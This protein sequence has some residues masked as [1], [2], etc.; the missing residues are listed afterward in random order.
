M[1]NIKLTIYGLLALGGL[2]LCTGCGLFRNTAKFRE[3]AYTE[4]E[5]YSRSVTDSAKTYTDHRADFAGSET[6]VVSE[7]A[8]SARWPVY[9]FAESVTDRL[10]CF[11]S[12]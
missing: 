7:T 5:R 6:Q 3:T 1:K 12:A 11:F 9:V 2:W 8:K 4:K 10:D